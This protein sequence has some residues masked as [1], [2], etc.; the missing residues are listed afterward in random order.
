MNLA[1]ISSL[2]SLSKGGAFIAPTVRDAVT[3]NLAIANDLDDAQILALVSQTLFTIL[4]NKQARRIIE[5]YLIQVH[6]TALFVETEFSTVTYSDCM[7]QAKTDVRQL[8]E[9]PNLDKLGMCIWQ[10]RAKFVEIWKPIITQ[11][12]N[13]Q[14]SNFSTAIDESFDL[15]QAA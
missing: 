8:L 15:L 3:K 5:F 14:F 2:T 13:L 11:L 1:V 9:F 12:D 7:S 10:N 6:A 4:D